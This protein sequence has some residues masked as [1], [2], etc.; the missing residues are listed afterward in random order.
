MGRPLSKRGIRLGKP[1]CQEYSAWR[2]PAC[3]N[4]YTALHQYPCPFNKLIRYLASLADI[5]RQLRFPAGACFP[6]RR[7]PL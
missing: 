6:L 5:A 1:Y 7:T 3:A 2:E 4:C